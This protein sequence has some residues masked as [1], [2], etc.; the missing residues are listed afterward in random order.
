MSETISSLIIGGQDAQLGAYPWMTGLFNRGSTRPFCGGTL[1]HPRWVL[2]AAHCAFNNSLIDVVVGMHE[3]YPSRGVRVPVDQVIIHPSYG[4]YLNS[5]DFALL[6]LSKPVMGVETLSLI[7]NEEQISGWNG[8]GYGV[9]ARAIGWGYIKYPGTARPTVLQ[10][11]DINILGIN[12][13]ELKSIYPDLSIYNIV[14]DSPQ[15]GKDTCN[16]DS[17]GPLLVSDGNGGWLHAGATSY[18][19]GCGIYPGVYAN[20]LT[21]RSWILSHL[22]PVEERSLIPINFGNI[23]STCECTE[24]LDHPVHEPDSWSSN[25]IPAEPGG[26]D[27]FGISN[28]I[29]IDNYTPGLD[30]KITNLS[31]KLL[32]DLK[33]YQEIN[34]GSSEDVL[35]LQLKPTPTPTPI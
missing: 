17:G 2:T 1:I 3:L 15:G 14:A 16:G 22:E 20:T 32:V 33:G 28:D 18:G 5:L 25:Y 4:G 11:V 7:S 26:F 34:P 24:C 13:P 10:Q 27:Y 6:R 23:D 30:L 35:K 31:I 21:A 9:S 29:M 19:I 12:S 8:S